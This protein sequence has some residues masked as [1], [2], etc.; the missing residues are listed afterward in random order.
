MSHS[1][2]FYRNYRGFQSGRNSGYSEWAYIVDRE[3]A[4]SPEHYTRAFSIIQNDLIKLFEYVEPSDINLDTYSYRI[5]EILMRT[6]IEIEANFKAIAKANIFNPKDNKGRLK[7]ENS[8]NI[9]D[10]KK[11]NITHRLSSYKVFIPIWNGSNST[12]EP[13]V[14]WNTSESLSLYQ[15]YNKS[16]HDRQNQFKEAN[17]KN[18]LNAI[19]GLLVLLSSQFRTEDFSPQQSVLSINTDSYYQTEPALGG[20]FHIQFPNDWPEDEKYNFDWST[21]KN[22]A[23]RFNKIDYDLIS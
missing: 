10:Y 17:L 5:H 3:Y 20:F 18:T 11:I 16:K 1:K 22:E 15:S 23:D 9:K 4:T 19:G 2:P 7:D 13:F 6:C 14:E 8:W 12:F 21:L